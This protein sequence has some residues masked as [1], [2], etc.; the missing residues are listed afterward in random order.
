MD[1][2]IVHPS[3]HEGDTNLQES[4]LVSSQGGSPPGGAG[5]RIRFRPPAE[6]FPLCHYSGQ[7]KN[8]L[9]IEGIYQMR[10]S[11]TYDKAKGLL[12]WL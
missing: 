10:V 1:Y 5:R 8:G 11:M 12:S 7:A 9:P 3:V 6:P 4:S 2:L